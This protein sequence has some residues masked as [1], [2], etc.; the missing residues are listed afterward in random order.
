MGTKIITRRSVQEVTPRAARPVTTPHRSPPSSRPLRAIAVVVTKRPWLADYIGR[1]LAWQTCRPSHV[2]VCTAVADYDLSPIAAQLAGVEVDLVVVP[3]E[4]VLGQLR[5]AAMQAAAVRSDEHGILCTIDDDDLYGSNYLEG[6]LDAWVR[7]PRALVIGRA[8][9]TVRIVTEPPREPHVQAS[10]R[11]G[12]VISVA[13]STICIPAS[14][15]YERP[16]FRYREI[17]IGEDIELLERARTQGEIISAYFGDY[18]ILRF[19]D[20]RH[21]HTSPSS[22]AEVA[23]KLRSGVQR[24]VQRVQGRGVVV[25]GT[26]R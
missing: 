1:K 26:I 14:A 18:V 24:G 9:Y 3:K 17:P 8:S 13:G 15:W 19:T 6:I 11:V 22:A 16:D 4:H 7:H 25:R 20:E 21:A 2:V 12:R 23:S 5:N 10:A